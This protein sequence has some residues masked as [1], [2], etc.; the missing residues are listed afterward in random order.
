MFV[1]EACRFKTGEDLD[2]PCAR[3]ETHFRKHRM[4]MITH[5]NNP[6]KEKQMA[7]V[8][9]LHPLFTIESM[10]VH[11]A[12]V[13]PKCDTHDKQNDNDTIKCFT[14]SSGEDLR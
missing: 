1:E 11:N 6:N 4:D 9:D 2:D 8:F 7:S 14:N 10:K 5:R 13:R 3:L 12:M